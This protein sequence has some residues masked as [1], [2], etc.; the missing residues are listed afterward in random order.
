LKIVS[1][2]WVLIWVPVPAN[3]DFASV[4]LEGIDP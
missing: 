3:R 4:P 2:A 1:G